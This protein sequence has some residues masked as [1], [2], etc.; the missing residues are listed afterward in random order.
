MVS[1][2]IPSYDSKEYIESCLNGIINQTFK[3]LEIICIDDGS[4]DGSLQI[5]QQ[6]AQMDCRIK[7]LRQENKGAAA[8]RNLGLKAAQGKYVIFLDSDDLFEP[9]LIEYA[10]SKAKAVEADMVVFKADTFDNL[11]GQISPLND[12]ISSFKAYQHKTFCCKD[13][14]A[15]IFNS[16]LIA[17]WNKLYRKSFLDRHGFTFQNIKRTNDLLFTSQTLAAAGRI[18][19]LEEVLLHYRVGLTKNLQSGNSE[20]PLDFYKALLALKKYLEEI[21]QYNLLQNSYTKMALEVV[22]YNLNSVKTETAFKK[23]KEFLQSEGF[24]ALGITECKKLYTLFFLGYLQYRC[25][26]MGGIFSSPQILG[27]LY[28][29]FKVQQYLQTAGLQGL[30]KKVKQNLLNN[31]RRNSKCK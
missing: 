2:I 11:T 24:K 14:P 26:K 21:G 22:F 25:I 6:Y 18:I 7:I 1:V 28:K 16:F 13:L 5:L 20:T 29:A 10:V 12:K 30:V 17:P 9:C 4:T 3:N 19:L 15:D 23:L 27:I 31:K 8:A